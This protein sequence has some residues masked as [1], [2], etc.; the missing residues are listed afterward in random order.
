MISLGGQGGSIC[1]LA[2]QG[3]VLYAQRK[4]AKSSVEW[5]GIDVVAD[6]KIKAGLHDLTQA[7]LLD[8]KAAFDEALHKVAKQIIVLPKDIRT[9]WKIALEA[10]AAPRAAVTRPSKA[11]TTT[12]SEILTADVVTVVEAVEAVKDLIDTLIT[13][14]PD[15][16]LRLE[17][18]KVGGVL[19]GNEIEGWLLLANGVAGYRNPE[20]GVVKSS[21]EVAAVKSGGE[22][23]RID[24]NRITAI[25]ANLPAG[26][27]EKRVLKQQV[28][29]YARLMLTGNSLSG[30]GSTMVAAIF[31]GQGNTWLRTG[32]DDDWMGSVVADRATF[33]GNLLDTYAS[34]DVLSSTVKK[35]LLASVGNVLIELLPQV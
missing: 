8:N 16:A 26:A 25:K 15:Y 28:A 30:Y 7:A 35:D 32:S 2:W 17:S 20:D 9:S 10:G 11:S 27:V 31:V 24:N 5:G 4:S 19:S 29:G 23:L 18:V 3:N 1:R 33:S 22:D 14:D 34:N 6:D 13:Y 12:M 21:L